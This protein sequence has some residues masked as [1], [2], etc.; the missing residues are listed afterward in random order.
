MNVAKEIEAVTLKFQEQSVTAYTI[1]IRH[2]KENKFFIVIYIVSFFIRDI[3]PL[4]VEIAAN[5]YLFVT[6]SEKD[7]R[8]QYLYII[9]LHWYVNTGA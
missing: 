4:I 5:I 9:N 3:I 2:L 8:L 6:N 7:F 1:V